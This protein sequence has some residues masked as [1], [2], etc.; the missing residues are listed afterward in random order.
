MTIFFPPGFG[1]SRGSSVARTAIPTS[2]HVVT[3]EAD[4]IL[5]ELGMDRPADASRL[6]LAKDE[7]ALAGDLTASRK[8]LAF[9]RADAVG[10][11]VRAL[12]WGDAALFGVDRVRDL[13]DWPLTAK[14]PVPGRGR[15]VRPGQ[16][17]DPVRRRRH[18]ARPGRVRD[19]PRRG[20]GKGADFPFDGGT[21]T[22]TGHC[23]DCSPLGWDLPYT[24]RTGHAGAFR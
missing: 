11:E 13:A 6:I 2:R 15:R 18:H 7:A 1:L 12:A 23:K 24:K 22:V 10:P 9:L 4:A 19:P 5:A 20:K 14:L 8:R 3:D 17:V 16:D 21:A